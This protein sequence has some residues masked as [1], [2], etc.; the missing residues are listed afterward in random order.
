MIGQSKGRSLLVMNR[1]KM[2]KYRKIH[3]VLLKILHQY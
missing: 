3:G 1:M 2:A